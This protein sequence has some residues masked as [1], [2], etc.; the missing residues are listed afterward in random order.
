MSTPGLDQAAMRRLNTSVI[1]RVLAASDGDATMQQLATATG[2]SRRTIEL[3]VTDLVAR[4]W[5][6]EVES[7]R[8]GGAGR[9]ARRFRFQAT[10]RVVA[11]AR[12]DT[13]LATAVVADLRGQTIGRAAAL[14]GD[15]YFDPARAVVRAAAVVRQAASVAGV[16]EERI[17]AGVVAVG[18]VVDDDGVMR[19]LVSA[20][21]W[22]GFDLTRAFE[23]ELGGAWGADNDANLAALAEYWTG[24]AQDTQH[25]AWLIHG[26]RTGAGFVLGG[27]VHHGAGGAAGEIIESRVLGLERDVRDPLGMLTSPLPE[28]RE[29]ALVRVREALDGDP[30]ARAEADRL[31]TQIADIVDVFAWTIAPELVVLGGGLEGGAELLVP[32]VR[33]RLRALDLP[34]IDVQPSAIGPDASLVGAVRRALD[35]ADADLY[36]PV[37]VGIT[38]GDKEHLR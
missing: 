33:A 31:A 14:L 11:A 23:D 6:T 3:I 27:E 5:A 36:G 8:S 10:R 1:L 16:D 24:V 19:R 32:L 7:E 25:S 18:G 26:R 37:A 2:L 30:A 21:R 9:P 38:P 20:P 29:A 22:S 13:E 12:I 15:D 35:L 28:D 34:D 4:G 17:A